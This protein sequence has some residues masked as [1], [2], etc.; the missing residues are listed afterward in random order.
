MK[1]RYLLL[2]CALVLFSAALLAGPLAR[3]DAASRPPD[4]PSAAVH[5][6]YLPLICDD[7]EGLPTPFPTAT[8]TSTETAT[9]TA[10]SK[11]T[12]TATSTET[13]TPTATSTST[14]TLTVT[15]TPTATSTSTETITPT[16]TLTPTATATPTETETATPSPTPTATSTETPEGPPG[17]YGRVTVNGQ[18]V[19][20]VYLVLRLFTGSAE[21]TQGQPVHTNA[22]G[23]YV[24]ADVPALKT[25]QTYFVL[26]QNGANGNSLATDRLSWWGSFEIGAYEDGARQ[27]GGDFDLAD[28]PLVTPADSATVKL[29]YTF[30][31]Q[32]R[33]N[34]PGDEYE[35]NLFDPADYQPWYYRSVGYE[36]SYLLNALPGGFAWNAPYRW[37]LWIYNGGGSGESLYSYQVKFLTGALLGN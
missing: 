14:A 8:A 11:P 21:T 4:G 20:G 26:Y 15:L 3:T 1:P 33:P 13:A 18:P 24:F 7:D 10:T 28:V 37:N 23:A 5:P 29:P 30:T 17:I 34:S 2:A 12:E 22:D 9:P 35:F 25:G 19:A 36:G 32:V 6:V 27:W 16:L 31:W